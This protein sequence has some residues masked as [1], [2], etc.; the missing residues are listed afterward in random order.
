[1]GKKGDPQG[2]VVIPFPDASV[3]EKQGEASLSLRL[4]R[5]FL[6]TK[7]TDEVAMTIGRN[8]SS[9]FSQSRFM[10]THYVPFG[11]KFIIHPNRFIL[12]ST[13]EWVKL[14]NSHSAYVAGKSSIGRHGVVIET[15][16]GVHPGFSGCLTL[17]I[18]NLGELPVALEPGMQICQLF[19]HAVVGGAEEARSRFEGRRKPALRSLRSDR[20]LERLGRRID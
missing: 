18:S 2:L 9:P 4:G 12:A 16:A 20:V 8:E 5:W 14:P 3:V 13:L 6:S 1:M 15:A 10:K 19:F 11:R 7:Q 17:E